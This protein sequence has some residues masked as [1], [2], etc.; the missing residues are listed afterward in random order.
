MSKALEDFKRLIK[1]H[2]P[3]VVFLPYPDISNSIG[4]FGVPQH[5]IARY[6]DL[7][8]NHRPHNEDVVFIMVSEKDTQ[9]NH[10]E[11]WKEYFKGR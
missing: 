2:I 9:N 5:K 7:M 4:V 6:Y 1:T 11:I 10:P 8:L 3:Q